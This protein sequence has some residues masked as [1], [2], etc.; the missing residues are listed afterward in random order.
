MER[1]GLARR[2]GVGVEAR[3]LR[4]AYKVCREKDVDFRNLLKRTQSALSELDEDLENLTYQSNGRQDSFNTACFN[5]CSVNIMA[6]GPPVQMEPVDLSLRSSKVGEIKEPPDAVV[7][8]YYLLRHVLTV[9]AHSRKLQNFE[10][11]LGALRESLLRSY[12]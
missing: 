8:W 12:N 1:T 6:E 10:K 9:P 4:W 7:C 11:D 3:P 2:F 5:G